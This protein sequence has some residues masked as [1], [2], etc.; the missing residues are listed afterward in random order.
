[1]MRESKIKKILNEIQNLSSDRVKDFQD[2]NRET[3]D[4]Q[5]HALDSISDTAKAFANNK[6]STPTIIFGEGGAR[7]VY[8]DGNLSQPEKKPAD[9]EKTCVGCGRQI[10]VSFKNC[11]HC[12]HKF[13]DM[14]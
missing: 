6:A 1:M 12:G 7:T 5:K 14:A 4:L 11:P 13:A 9:N 8:S 3:R 10:D 2:A